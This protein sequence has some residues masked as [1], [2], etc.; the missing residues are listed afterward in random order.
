MVGSI[1]KT[2]WQFVALTSKLQYSSLQ[3]ENV[4]EKWSPTEMCRVIKFIKM[5]AE[6]YT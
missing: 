4:L 2:K 1:K 3:R 5:S 6:I